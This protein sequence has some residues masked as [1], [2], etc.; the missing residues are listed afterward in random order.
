VRE[1]EFALFIGGGEVA[2]DRA[3]RKYLEFTRSGT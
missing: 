1:R 2:G 3:A